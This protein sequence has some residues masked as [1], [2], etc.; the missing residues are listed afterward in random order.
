MVEEKE[1]NIADLFYTNLYIE[2]RIQ[3]LKRLS[4]DRVPHHHFHNQ[5]AMSQDPKWKMEQQDVEALHVYVRVLGGVDT[6]RL[7]P[8]LR[9]VG[10]LYVYKYTSCY[11]PVRLVPQPKYGHKRSLYR[12]EPTKEKTK[13]KTAKLIKTPPLGEHLH[14]ENASS[15]RSTV[16]FFARYENTPAEVEVKQSAY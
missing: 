13:K 5:K 14:W 10:K 9:E 7:P 16:P 2:V 11:G 1:A 12:K 4:I 15:K 3:S 8:T 6:L